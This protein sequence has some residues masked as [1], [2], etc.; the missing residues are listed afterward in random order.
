MSQGVRNPL[1]FEIDTNGIK[2][3]PQLQPQPQPA[4]AAVPVRVAVGMAVAG[5]LRRYGD[6]IS[7]R[8]VLRTPWIA[9]HRTTIG[10]NLSQMHDKDIVA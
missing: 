2:S 3:Q 4:A 8:I 9:S 7:Y 10:D 1:S 6:T 5:G